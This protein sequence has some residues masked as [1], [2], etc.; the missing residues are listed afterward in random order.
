[1]LSGQKHG[2]WA[3]E[4]T[5]ANSYLELAE[6]IGQQVLGAVVRTETNSGHLSGA[7]EATPHAIVDTMGLAP[8]L[9][10]RSQ[11]PTRNSMQH[12]GK[13]RKQQRDGLIDLVALHTIRYTKSKDQPKWPS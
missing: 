11:P 4:R 13:E 9:L 6:T 3:I 2:N 12:A 5:L 8:A 1:M 7:L 10:Q